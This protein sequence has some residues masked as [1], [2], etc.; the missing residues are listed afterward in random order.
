M[1]WIKRKKVRLGPNDGSGIEGKWQWFTSNVWLV[2]NTLKFSFCSC[3]CVCVLH[4]SHNVNM[5][6]IT[7]IFRMLCLVLIFFT[8]KFPLT[9]LLYMLYRF[10]ANL[11]PYY[12]GL[13][14]YVFYN[15][16]YPS[17]TRVLRILQRGTGWNFVL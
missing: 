5:P 3:V 2:D 11:S 13:T 10:N 1:D 6:T 8:C 9:H 15:I 17:K 4:F 16:R 14:F 12:C 7:I